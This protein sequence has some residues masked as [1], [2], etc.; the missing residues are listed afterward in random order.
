MGKMQKEKGKRGERECAAELRRLLNWPENG[1]QI[2]RGQQFSGSPDSP[3]V[4]VPGVPIH[5]EV[6][7]VEGCGKFYKFMEQAEADSPSTSVPVVW[8]RSNAQESL[9]VCKWKNIQQLAKIV[10]RLCED[11]Q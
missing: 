6:K 9:L 4:I 7:R 2:R 8:V 1:E 10:K 11:E 5:V 3:D